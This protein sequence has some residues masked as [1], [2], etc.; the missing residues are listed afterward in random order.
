MTSHKYFQFFK[1][2]VEHIIYNL[3]RCLINKGNYGFGLELFFGESLSLKIIYKNMI[4]KIF[5]SHFFYILPVI[6]TLLKFKT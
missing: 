4:Y 3:I 2:K 6:H 1:L 5:I